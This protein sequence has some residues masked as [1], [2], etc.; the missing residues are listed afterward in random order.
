MIYS[1]NNIPDVALVRTLTPLDWDRPDRETTLERVA[2]MGEAVTQLLADKN[3]YLTYVIPVA[4]DEKIG[5]TAYYLNR[6]LVDQGKNTADVS[7]RELANEILQS[8]TDSDER[9]VKTSLARICQLAS[10]LAD[11]DESKRLVLVTSEPFM[12]GAR[13]IDRS[14][15]GVSDFRELIEPGEVVGV[16]S[17]SF[18]ISSPNILD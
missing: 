8:R 15:A 3:E 12:I 2:R 16:H 9:A 5:R 1:D 14:A 10:R 4:N 18:G 17:S 11:W 7:S 13:G 6:A